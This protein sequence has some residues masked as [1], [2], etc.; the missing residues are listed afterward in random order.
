MHLTAFMCSSLMKFGVTDCS[1]SPDML[2]TSN[3]VSGFKKHCCMCAGEHYYISS[4]STS[5]SCPRVR[6]QRA[7]VL[8]FD[9]QD[10]SDVWGWAE[11][12]WRI[13]AAC[14]LHGEKKKAWSAID[15]SSLWQV[16]V[17]VVNVL[18]LGRKE[19][20]FTHSLRLHMSRFGD[21][22]LI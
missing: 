17:P 22:G 13:P 18:V 20:S 19:E 4:Q 8:G 9:W 21:Y 3:W 10:V 14:S 6:W 16:M 11:V 2:E 1:S 7:A 15:W 12:I 5:W